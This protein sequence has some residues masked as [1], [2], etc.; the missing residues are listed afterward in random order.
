MNFVVR[1]A[2][3]QNRSLTYGAVFLASFLLYLLFSA[4][5]P[6]TDPVESN[7]A[8]TAKE[9]V[10][11]ADW[12]SPR[13]YG[14]VWYDKPVFFY[15]LIA[16]SFKLF[17]L[18]ELAARLVPALFAAGGLTFLYWFAKVVADKTTALAAVVILGTSVEYVMLAKL[19]ITDMVFFWF[20]S[21]ALALFYLGYGRWRGTKK[22][23]LAMYVCLALAVLTKGPVGLLLPGLVMIIYIGLE[24]NWSELKNMSI[25]LGI[26][27]F[28]FVAVPWYAAM[29]LAHGSD[30]ISTF[31]GVHNYLR[32][33]VSEHPKDNVA[34]YY[35]VVFFLS[36]LPWSAVAAK[37][38]IAGFKSFR[39]E[40]SAIS[41]FCLVWTAVYFIF[42]SLMATKYLT[43]IF[44]ILFPA[45]ILTGVYLANVF[46]KGDSKTIAY[47][48][49]MPAGFAALVYTAVAWRYLT[50]A[51]LAV[52]A[53]S[54][55][56]PLAF[57]WRRA[58]EGKDATWLF[59]HLVACQLVSLLTLS[60]L[61]FPAIASS[62][63]AK[64]MA[65]T[66]SDIAV[67]KV[68][69]YRFYDTSAVFYGG[70]VAVKL[71]SPDELQSE[72]AGGLTWTKKYTMPA[73][74]L[75]DFLSGDPA[76]VVVV[77][78][79]LVAQFSAEAGPFEPELIKSANGHHYYLVNH[80]MSRR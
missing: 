50:G 38:I 73:Q 25:P 45:S 48:C 3:M 36:L 43:Y 56:A 70:A 79:K 5:L 26:I 62:R 47:W 17:G 9:M 10:E 64:D 11:T 31:F 19:I 4:Q 60:V 80:G 67:S 49:G 59:K 77:P 55:L 22:W 34:Y 7:Y 16:L 71:L 66:I 24:R 6:V 63:S 23:Y 76:A 30:F 12:L 2:I 20:N 37:A 28:A 51:G 57:V 44:P 1:I 33:T 13:I 32:A 75:A 39:A 27:L 68:G 53:I 72:A 58:G 65:N 78:D 54:L 35:V 21:L 41:L 14:N 69:H 74:T 52:A 15:W 8:L 61:V 42:Y 46:A 40:S 18:T 29:Y